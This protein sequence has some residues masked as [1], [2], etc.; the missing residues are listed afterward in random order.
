MLE[1]GR[2]IVSGRMDLLKFPFS[3]RS[4]HPG[5]FWWPGPG[6]QVSSL[7][8]SFLKLLMNLLRGHF[9]PRSSTKLD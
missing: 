3:D 9:P 6:Q 1:V 7:L 2:P 4:P 5:S 8:L